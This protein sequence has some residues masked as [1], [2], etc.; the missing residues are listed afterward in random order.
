MLHNGLLTDIKSVSQ[1]NGFKSF[2]S[3]RKLI[4]NSTVAG[5]LSVYDISGKNVLE[6]N[7]SEGISSNN[8]P[9]T[10]GVYILKFIAENGKNHSEKII[11]N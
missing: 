4:T 2:V 11:I 1:D 9:T 3:N 5:K 7:L 6:Q 8:L 10:A